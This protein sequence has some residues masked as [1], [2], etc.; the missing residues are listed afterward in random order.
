MVCQAGLPRLVVARQQ[1]IIRKMLVVYVEKDG[2]LMWKI[3]RLQYATI[4]S[5]LIYGSLRRPRGRQECRCATKN[6]EE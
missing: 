6:R 4:N 1:G 3:W 5:W 2:E